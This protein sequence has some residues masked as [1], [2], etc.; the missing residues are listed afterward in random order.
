MNL[1]K[2][3]TTYSIGSSLTIYEY[4]VPDLVR[5]GY[6]D[7]KILISY[8]KSNHTFHEILK[9]DPKSDSIF[10]IS[11]IIREDDFFKLMEDLLEISFKKFRPSLIQ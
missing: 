4:G 5:F 11:L 3:K 10:L 9:L 6:E 1:D 8:D 7:A 2:L